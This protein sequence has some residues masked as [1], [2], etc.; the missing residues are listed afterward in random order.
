M[1][2]VLFLT[3]WAAGFLLLWRVP[4]PAPAG[5]RARPSVSVIVPARDEAA[6][7]PDLLDSLRRQQPPP[8]E[9]IV[10]DDHSAD[11]TAAVARAGGARVLAAP[12]L[13]EGWCGKSWACWQGALVARGELLLFLDADVRLVE[14]GLA[15]LVATFA[16]AGGLLSVQ[17]YHWM[18]RAD[19]Q[20]AAFFNL[21]AVAGLGAFAW[22]AA[23]PGAAVAFGPC[24]LCRNEDYLRVDGHRSARAAV[25]ESLPLAR[26]FAAH[27]LPVRCY[28]GAGTVLYRMYPGGWTELMRGFG[29]SLALGAGAT[30]LP[31]LLLIGAWLS[32][33]FDAPRRLLTAAL[34]CDLAGIGLFLVCYLLYA[35]QLAW[36]LR[37]I[38]RFHWA[39]AL[40]YP[41]PLSFFLGVFLKSL[42]ESFVFGRVAWKGRSIRTS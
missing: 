40:A 22:R 1:G 27:G 35:L 31:R 25:V 12:P 8:E 20:L 36:M 9:I 28:G 15:R 42:L 26:A 30:P 37:R 33:G 18:E 3:L 39:T 23:S 10:I 11:A 4:L 41:L 24:N 34:L 29:K 14:G 17:P 19:E 16:G 38:G 13:P 7:L 32:A 5:A 21:V 6:N 2:L